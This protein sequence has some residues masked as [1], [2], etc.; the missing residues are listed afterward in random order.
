[1]ALALSGTLAGCGH[2]PDTQLFV[3]TAQAAKAPM[4]YAGP[5]LQVRTVHLPPQFDRPE[6]L[7]VD[8]TGHVHPHPF[9]QWAAPV[10]E[11]AQSTLTADLA[12]RL[13]QGKVIFPNAPAPTGTL[14]V[15][16]DILDARIS[17]GGGAA[18]A[19]WTVT[20]RGPKA[21]DPIQA[22]TH[23]GQL[24][25]EPDGLGPAADADALARLLSQL[26][27]QIAASL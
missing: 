18:Q 24:H 22:V 21:T 9:A 4:A 6:I 14:L 23:T 19:S 25:V 5:P 12:A 27:D 10:G 11:L 8:E 13:P 2:S 15:T 3:L 16:V 7:A 17:G 26:A 20:V 1:L